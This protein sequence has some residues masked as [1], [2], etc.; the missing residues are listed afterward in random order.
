MRL[1]NKD[2]LFRN[3]IKLI[4]GDISFHHLGLSINDETDLINRIEIVVHAAANIRFNEPLLELINCNV[5][6]TREILRLSENMAKLQLFV[7]VSSAHA[8]RPSG[9]VQEQFYPTTLDPTMLIDLADM[10]QSETDKDTFIKLTNT[11]IQPWTNSYFFTKVLC[12]ELVRQYSDRIS[13]TVI[14]PSIRKLLRIIQGN[15][16]LLFFFMYIVSSTSEDPIPGW[17]TSIYGLNGILTGVAFGYIRCLQNTG[18]IDVDIICA[19]FVIN[20]TMAIIWDV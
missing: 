15:I 17:S 13:V 7:Y 4:G 20:S 12:E 8:A 16:L 10:T 5:R 3:K 19:D 18:N 6:G 11:I 14:R 1:S 2:P 9:H